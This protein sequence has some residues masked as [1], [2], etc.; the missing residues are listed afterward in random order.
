[1]PNEKES[2]DE[3]EKK[4]QPTP[5]PDDIN[6]GAYTGGTDIHVKPGDDGNLPH[7]GTHAPQKPK[8]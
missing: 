4:P 2:K 1:M 7:E 3:K 8:D 5:T 6:S